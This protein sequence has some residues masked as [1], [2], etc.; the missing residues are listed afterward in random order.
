MYF[1][2]DYH[3]QREESISI[4]RFMSFQN[5]FLPLLL[6]VTL[7]VSSV[8]SNWYSS[9]KTCECWSKDSFLIVPPITSVENTLSTQTEILHDTDEPVN[10]P[11]LFLVFEPKINDRNES[12]DIDEVKKLI[13]VVPEASDDFCD[14]FM[15][16][17]FFSGSLQFLVLLQK[18]NQNFIFK[19]TR[20]FPRWSFEPPIYTD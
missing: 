3:L 12:I 15:E 6:N 17:D 14:D 18:L 1:K 16:K 11:C 4:T 2:R 5:P 8:V 13:L 19:Q 20:S 9:T 7:V 10:G